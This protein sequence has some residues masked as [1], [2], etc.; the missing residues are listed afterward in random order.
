MVRKHPW[1]RSGQVAEGPNDE[2]G[3]GRSRMGS[4]SAS[5]AQSTL[6][7]YKAPKTRCGPKRSRPRPSNAIPAESRYLPTSS[8]AF[9][10]AFKT[11]R[12][13]KCPAS[14]GRIKYRYRDSNPVR[15]HWRSRR[16]QP[17]NRSAYAG[18][19]WARK[20]TVFRRA[21]SH[22]REPGI[23]HEG[24]KFALLRP[25]PCQWRRR[26][27]QVRNQYT[28]DSASGRPL[29]PAGLTRQP[30]SR[31]GGLAR[32]RRSDQRTPCVRRASR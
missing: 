26:V 3:A 5:V 21:R 22:P 2:L 27:R 10:L 14:K 11:S 32:W 4:C 6:R 13:A 16:T 1:A 28:A 17:C 25:Y 15:G 30:G 7:P 12:N 23:P 24:A 19:P 9:M 29:A 20:S 8:L 18:R 31:S